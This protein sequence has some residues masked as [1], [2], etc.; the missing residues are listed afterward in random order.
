MTSH[1]PSWFAVLSGAG[2]GLLWGIVA[3]IWM[4]LISTNPEF[5]IEG[6]AYIL[7]VATLFGASTG[8]A[9]SARQRAWRGWRQ[10]V[11]RSL[12]V[13]F[14]LSFGVAG[15]IP[16]M[17][18][19]LIFTLGITQSPIIGLWVVTGLTLLVRM[20]T[21]INIPQW[22]ADSLL[23]SAVGFTVWT[24]LIH[25]RP[26]NRLQFV[27]RWFNRVVRLLL[28]MLA[29]IGVGTVAWEIMSN[30]AIGYAVLYVLFY[31]VLLSPLFWGL[32]VA[33]A[34]T[35]NAHIKPAAG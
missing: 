11:P 10:Y 2:C 6:T 16:L 4:R 1:L 12:V 34:P 3:R 14:F 23:I 9:F 7:I 8:L 19:M 15:G 31:L 26:D 35:Q 13:I 25:K 21:D 17:L 29:L 27:N 33:F 5:S 32:R 18:T 24:W 28:V 30:H 20:A 22:L